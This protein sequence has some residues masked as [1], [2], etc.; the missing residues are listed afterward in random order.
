M[1]LTS[2]TASGAV[3]EVEKPS[4]APPAPVDDVQLMSQSMVIV[5]WK[6]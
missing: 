5:V 6:W 1:P 4:S 2:A 3:V